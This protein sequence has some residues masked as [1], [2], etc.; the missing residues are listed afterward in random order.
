M[1]IKATQ[2]LSGGFYQKLYTNTSVTNNGVRTGRQALR[3]LL[4]VSSQ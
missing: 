3:P 2:S 4:E 1:A